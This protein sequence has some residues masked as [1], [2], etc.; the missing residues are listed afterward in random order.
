MARSGRSWLR[1]VRKFGLECVSVCGSQRKLA[2]RAGPGAGPDLDL[3]FGPGSVLGARCSVDLEAK[4]ESMCVHC[5]SATSARRS[6][7]G[8]SIAASCESPARP[9]AAQNLP[10]VATVLHWTAP[11]V[12]EMGHK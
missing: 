12:S 1:G 4:G 5:A 6:S 11:A 7:V 9:D 8:G 3:A 2:A 10:V